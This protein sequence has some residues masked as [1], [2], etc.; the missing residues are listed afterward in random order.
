MKNVYESR[1]D[2]VI[3]G[4]MMPDGWFSFLPGC[5][6]FWLV[7]APASFAGVP[8]QDVQELKVMSWNIWHGGRE[9]GKEDG[10]K[11]V[12]QIIRQSGADLIAVQETYGSGELLASMTGFQLHARGTNVSILSRYPLAE[13]VSCFEE[14]KC[15]GGVFEIPEKAGGSGSRR[16]AFYSIWLPY[17]AE[18]WEQ[19][20]RNPADRE[21]M[22]AACE[23]SAA[24]LKK[25]LVEIQETLSKKGYGEIPVFLAGDFNSMSHLDYSTANSDQYEVA[26]NWPT[27]L[28]AIRAGFCDSFREVNPVVDRI[29]DRTWTPRFPQQEQDRIDFIYF[30]GNDVQ[31]SKSAIID[32]VPVGLFPSDHA[33]VVSSFLWQESESR[34][35]EPV[36]EEIVV[37]SYN[38]RHGTGNDEKLDLNRT[39]NV[40]ASMDCDIVGVQEVDFG[41][42]RSG[43]I[44]QTSSLG[45]QLGMYGAFGKFMD[46]QKGQYGIAVFSRLPVRETWA[47]PLPDGEEPRSALGIRVQTRLNQFFTATSVHFDWIDDDKARFE[48]ATALIAALQELQEPVL[49]LGD[50]NDQPDSRTMNL[51]REIGIVCDETGGTWP[52]T[53]PDQRIDYIVAVPKSRWEIVRSEVISE[54]EASDHRPIRSVVRLLP[55]K[56]A[57]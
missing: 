31:V 29:V 11:Q 28:L 42:T 10:P 56:H 47:I 21:G 43:G 15:V 24:D 53:S 46:F 18:I 9:N 39:G 38:I 2:E 34:D 22:L 49:V 25:L 35:D 55:R 30:R 48:Q 51:F 12:A 8:V 14:F 23:P 13:D 40:I 27:S 50:F 57:K 41:T 6:S 19:G 54:P 52:A 16:F 37:G 26:V 3:Q 4:L 17:A 7:I 1:I 45:R 44:N 36:S 5:F 33:A 32:K 20:T